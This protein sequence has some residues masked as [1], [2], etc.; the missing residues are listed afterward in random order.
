[1]SKNGSFHS[2][3]RTCASTDSH[4]E[5]RCQRTGTSWPPMNW[6]T[7]WHTCFHSKACEHDD[8]TCDPAAAARGGHPLRAAR[9][10]IVVY[11]PRSRGGRTAQLD[12]VL[13]RLLR[14]AAQ[15]VATDGYH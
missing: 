13:G 4:G 2:S 7:C 9:T 1:M 8:Q 15:P 11:T 5:S 6:L 14:A 3:R 10:N 12:D